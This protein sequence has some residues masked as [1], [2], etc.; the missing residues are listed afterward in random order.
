MNNP[1]EKEITDFSEKLNHLWRE[2]R[3]N[4]A[5][6]LLLTEVEKYPNEYFLW[7][8]LSQTCSRLGEYVSALAFSKKAIEICDDDVLVLYN[9]VTAL[10][11]T[12]SYK[13]AIPFCQQIL[14]KDIESIAQNGEGI[15]WAKSI[16]NDTL[17]L[18]AVALFHLGELAHALCVLNQLL[19]MR[20]RGV[21]SDFT[22]RQILNK[23]KAIE[24]EIPEIGDNGLPQQNSQKMEDSNLSLIP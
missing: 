12:E 9:H 4:E 19:G 6:M 14:E 16:R 20:A 24:H 8:S 11:E 22:K 5:K 10:V 7:T 15:K 2:Q 17:Y 18:K 3:M 13:D 1:S 23:I 21:Y